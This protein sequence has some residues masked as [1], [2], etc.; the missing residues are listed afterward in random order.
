MCRHFRGQLGARLCHR[1]FSA[2]P[3]S[4]AADFYVQ[5]FQ[6]TEYFSPERALF[7]RLSV[8]VSV[9]LSVTLLFPIYKMGN[10]GQILYFKVSKEAF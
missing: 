8:C 9:Y 2:T 4:G 1:R 6:M 5:S 3:A 10:N 7:V